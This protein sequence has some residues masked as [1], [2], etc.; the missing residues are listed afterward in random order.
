MARSLRIANQGTIGDGTI[1]AVRVGIEPLM[2]HGQVEGS[3][4]REHAPL[5]PEQ[6]TQLLDQMPLGRPGRPMLGNKLLM[7]NRESGRVFPG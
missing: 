7:Q 2:Q 3:L 1:V 6:D 5:A 4:G